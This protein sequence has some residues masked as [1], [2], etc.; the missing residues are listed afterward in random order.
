MYEQN[1]IENATFEQQLKFRTL[2]AELDKESAAMEPYSRRYRRELRRYNE[3]R[4]EIGDKP[5]F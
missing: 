1:Q 4:A 2:M 5:K 3:F